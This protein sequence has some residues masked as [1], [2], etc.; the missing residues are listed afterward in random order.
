MVTNDFTYSF[1]AFVAAPGFEG[2]VVR[3]GAPCATVDEVVVGVLLCEL[4]D[5]SSS[6]VA[7]INEDTRDDFMQWVMK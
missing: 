3:T 5:A 1:H 2:S 4:H 6:A 7:M